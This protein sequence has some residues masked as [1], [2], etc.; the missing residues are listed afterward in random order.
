M[1]FPLKNNQYPTK[2]TSQK[3]QTT[4]TKKTCGPA[5]EYSWF[6]MTTQ[7]ESISK[8]FFF[9]HPPSDPVQVLSHQTIILRPNSFS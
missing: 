3:P 1:F 9:S 7:L 8:L 2:T 6:Q 4:A 5:R